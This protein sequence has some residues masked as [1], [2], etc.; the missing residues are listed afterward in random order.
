M[1]LEPGPGTSPDEEPR[2]VKKPTKWMTN[3]PILAKLLQARCN[4]QHEHVRLESSSRT[5]QAESY[6]VALV[7]AILN[8]VHQTKRMKMDANMAK[9]PLHMQIPEMFRQC[10][11][12]IKVSCTRKSMSRF[13]ANPP[14]TVPWDSVVV[15]RTIDRKTGV[16]MAEGRVFQGNSYRVVFMG[17]YAHGSGVILGGGS[18]RQEKI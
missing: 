16:V 9:D 13:D 5:K 12:N 3:S 6:P 15:R 8:K 1:T 18:W 14:I 2:L 11:N 7:K 10:E 17:R 4:G